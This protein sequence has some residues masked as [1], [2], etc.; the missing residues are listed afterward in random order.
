ML[1]S[2][3]S[4]LSITC[5]AGHYA[6]ATA[7]NGT[8]RSFSYP[9]LYNDL[10][11]QN[12]SFYIGVG[13]LG[14]GNL[15]QQ[16]V[17]ALF[18]AVTHTPAVTQP[19]ADATTANG[20]GFI[21]TGGTG[22]CVP[23]SYWDIGVRGD[24]GPANHSSGITLTPEA[25]VLT[26]ISGYAGG[27]TGFQ[28]NSASNPTVVGQYCNGSRVPP[29]LGSMG[30]QVPPGIA[31]ATVPNPIFNL[32]PAA[33]VD[34]GNN[35][36]NISWGPL[37]LTNPVT[38]SHLGDYELAAGSPAI[39][40]ITAANSS[41]T[42]AAAPATDFFGTQRK[43]NN[44]V[45]VGAV[46]FASTANVPSL[47]SITPNSGLRGSSVSVTLI[48]ADLSGAT[49][50]SVSGA[51]F[52]T[53]IPFTVVN[54]SE[55]TATFTIAATAAATARNVTVTTPVATSNAVTF[56]VLA[57]PAPTLT[58]IVPNSGF[59]GT[60]VNVVLSGTNLTGATALTGVGAGIT[61]TGFAVNTAGTQITATFQIAAGAALTAR[62][63]TVTNA[64]GTSNGVTFTVVMQTLTSVNPPSG[65]RGTS[66]PVTLTGTGLSTATAVNV[67][68]VNVNASFT[69]VNSTTINAIIIINP[70]AA[71]GSH[72]V[73][74]TTAG[75]NTNN[76]P[77]T[78]LGATVA[79]AGPTPVMNGGGLTTKPGTITVSNTAAGATAGPLTLTAVPTFTRVSGTGT[80]TFSIT[81]GGTCVNGAVVNPG[82]SCTINVQYVPTNTATAMYNVTIT[83]SG[84]SQ[85]SRTS[86]NFPVN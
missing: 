21:I 58:T 11:W 49:S 27:S 30:Y 62:T 47:S 65:T 32:T 35:W 23:A 33:T 86:P 85:V 40:Y 26:S 54:D 10:F 63:I 37:A 82:S 55:I 3:P 48:G 51:G 78:V 13:S 74:V 28:V 41:V 18:N 52:T 17:V 24:T 71:L 42:Y 75:G 1:A 76:V 9:I 84:D 8:C 15:N 14:A 22:A 67:T 64:G 59:R 81:T 57:P 20:G 43:T 4:T 36:I 6:G 79:F 70:A 69:I 2:L 7:T 68:G 12:R 44:A 39:N 45:D 61:V 77:F 25:S 83:D 19:Q 5:P 60:N 38:G 53:P 16:N 31:D 66:V 29:E 72:N 34:E 46:E 73:M 50:V 80:G 56:T